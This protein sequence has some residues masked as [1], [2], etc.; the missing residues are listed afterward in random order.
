MPAAPRPRVRRRVVGIP[1]LV[2]LLAMLHVAC[3]TPGGERE[4]RV[5]AT[6]YNSHPSQTRGDPNRAAWGDVL[7]PG[8]RAIAVS[9][10]LIDLGLTHGTRVRIEGLEGEYLVM[11]KMAKRW[12]RRI[13]V[14]MGDDLEAARSWGRRDVR[15][16]WL[17]AP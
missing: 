17:P 12:K 1:L 8:M 2:A 11:D 6:A 7:E 10:D 9:R 14:Y 3:A 5:T 15:I 16:S 13:D 4:L